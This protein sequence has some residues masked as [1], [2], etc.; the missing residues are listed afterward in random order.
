[1]MMRLRFWVI[2]R[3]EWP[4][5]LSDGFLSKNDETLPLSQPERRID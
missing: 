3:V 1:M 5:V 2:S 4:L